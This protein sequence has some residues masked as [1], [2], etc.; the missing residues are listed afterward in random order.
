MNNSS[1]KK[2]VFYR[3]TQTIDNSIEAIGQKNLTG[4]RWV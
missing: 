4:V 2:G 1:H 3:D